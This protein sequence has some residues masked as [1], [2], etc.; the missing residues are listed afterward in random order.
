MNQLAARHA[1]KNFLKD[2][3][4]SRLYDNSFQANTNRFSRTREKQNA[5]RS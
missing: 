5:F 4:Q 1:L 3:S 2:I